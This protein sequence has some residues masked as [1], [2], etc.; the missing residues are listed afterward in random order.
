M[1]KLRLPDDVKYHEKLLL[2]KP[3]FDKIYIVLVLSLI[4]I[5]LLTYKKHFILLKIILLVVA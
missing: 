5:F 2:N 4:E 1:I 3:Y